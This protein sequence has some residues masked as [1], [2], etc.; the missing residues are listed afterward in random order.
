MFAL[1]QILEITMS[2]DFEREVQFRID[3]DKCVSYKGY[4]ASSESDEA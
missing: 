2:V 1:H 3:Q 4:G